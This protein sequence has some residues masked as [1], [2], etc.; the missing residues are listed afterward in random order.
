MIVQNFKKLSGEP[1]K[2]YKFWIDKLPVRFFDKL[3]PVLIKH[4]SQQRDLSSGY[5]AESC[6]VASIPDFVSLAPLMQ[7]LG[8][9]V[10]GI[11][12]KDSK[13]IGPQW[14]G[15]VWQDKV[16]RMKE[17]SNEFDHLAEIVESMKDGS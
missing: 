3:R 17:F 1:K 2:G 11:E 7:E 15:N 5:N 8:K 10:F 16:A 4:S 14:Q 12:Q 6:I 9:P 13:A